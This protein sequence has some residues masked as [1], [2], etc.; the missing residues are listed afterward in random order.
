MIR[1]EGHLSE[2]MLSELR[3]LTTRHQ[4]TLDV[5]GLLGVDG[6]SLEYLAGLWRSGCK[7]I[8]ASPYLAQ[9]LAETKP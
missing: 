1:I 9:L 6:A 5:R 4:P 7:V 8:G 2:A 3:T